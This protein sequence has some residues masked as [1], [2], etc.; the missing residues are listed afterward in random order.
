MLVNGRTWPFLEVEQRRYRFRILN[1][2]NSRFLIL[3]L[4]NGLPFWQIGTEGGFLRAPVQLDAA[5]DVAGG[6]GGRDRRL[7][8]V[9]AGTEIVLQNLAPDEP[10]GGGVPGDRL[11]AGRPRHDRPGDAVPGRAAPRR[12][13]E[14]AA[15]RGSSC[16]G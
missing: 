16:R 12:D 15:A 11:H 14:H 6:A 2:C 1:G 8:R 7:H 5:P 10:F 9:P 3:K 4:D 13:I